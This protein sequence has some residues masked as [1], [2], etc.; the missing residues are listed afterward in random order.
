MTTIPKYKPLTEA[1]DWS[2]PFWI[3]GYAKTISTSSLVG[4]GLVT[5]SRGLE[6]TNDILILFGMS[7][8]AIAFI[9]VY[10]IDNYG[11]KKKMEEV[12]AIDD[13]NLELHLMNINLNNQIDD[14][15]DE[16]FKERTDK[17][18]E[19]MGAEE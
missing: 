10:A 6:I 14:L 5:I 11:E 9:S 1:L 19:N 15:I 7:C 16:K 8:I 3:Q 12:K 2:T 4:T 13:R 17:F 18:V